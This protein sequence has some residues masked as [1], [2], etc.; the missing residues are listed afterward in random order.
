MSDIKRLWIDY[1]LKGG[2]EHAE[3]VALAKALE[4]RGKLPS[5]F[6]LFPPVSRNADIW[7]D[8][9]RMHTLNTKQAQKGA[10]K[11]VCP[12][13]LDIIKRLITR[14]TQEGETVYDP[15]M[16]IGSVAY[17]ALK[18]GRRALGT[19]LNDEYW[20]F[21]VGYAEAVEAEVGLPTLFEMTREEMKAAA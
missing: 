8:I 1:S 12:L 7:T 9:A 21:S 14:Y 4:D 11:H 18:M 19:E 6:M 15:F 20:R 3:H 2:Y 16:G 13:Q 10:E 17:Q 5:S